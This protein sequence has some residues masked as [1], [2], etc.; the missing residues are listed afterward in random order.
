MFVLE[1]E[2]RKPESD[3]VAS[4]DTQGKC[5]KA[6][7]GEVTSSAGSRE[8][9]RS[10]SLV[11]M[12][13]TRPGGG[14]VRT[15]GPSPPARRS[16]R[17]PSGQKPGPATADSSAGSGLCRSELERQRDSWHVTGSTWSAGD[18]FNGGASSAEAAGATWEQD[19]INPPEIWSWWKR[20]TTSRTGTNRIQL[21]EI[22][23]WSFTVN[24]TLIKINWTELQRISLDQNHWL[25]PLTNHKH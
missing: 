8:P 14:L 23:N 9:L 6:L 13:Q 19:L 22:Y 20:R 21:V 12:V 17:P 16:I 2:T 1:S 24:S 5:H 10:R 15:S 4:T 11:L 7:S 3:P 18:R 25:A